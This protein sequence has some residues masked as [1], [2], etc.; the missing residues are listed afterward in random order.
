MAAA[1]ALLAHEQKQAVP[2]IDLP[3]GPLPG[4]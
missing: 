3:T 1:P 2:L 4:I